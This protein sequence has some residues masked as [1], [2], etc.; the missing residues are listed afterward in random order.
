[1]HYIRNWKNLTEIP[2][3]PDFGHDGAATP[4]WW[5]HGPNPIRRSA[6]KNTVLTALVLFVLAAP[7]LAEDPEPVRL[8]HIERNTNANIVVYDLLVEPGGSIQEKDPIDVHWVRLAEEGQRKD[9]SGIERRMAYGYKEKEREG[10]ELVIEMRADIGRLITVSALEGA[11]K[12]RID[13]NG[14]AAF[15]EKVFIEANEGFGLPSVEFIE[16]HGLD[17]ESGEP[18][19]EKFE[20]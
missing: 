18:A 4:R 3:K 13:I 9:L 17:A 5:Y 15:L 6:L 19:Y 2:K 14:K 8:F 16:L 20:P 7:A 12:A 10:N 1:M 11:Y